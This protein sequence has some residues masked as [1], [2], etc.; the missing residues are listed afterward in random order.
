MEDV[1]DKILCG[2]QDSEQTIHVKQ[3]PA[4]S[5]PMLSGPLTVMGL[6]ST[7]VILED[8]VRFRKDIQTMVMAQMLN[9]IMTEEDYEELI[10]KGSIIEIATVKQLNK[11]ANGDLDS[12]KYLMDR[13][14]GKPVNQTNSVSTVINYEQVLNDLDPE[15]KIKPKRVFCNEV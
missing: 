12:F 14:L 5:L 8:P 13:V 3:N 15:E 10:N 4:P 7:P 6:H 1:L 11:A 2:G 9:G